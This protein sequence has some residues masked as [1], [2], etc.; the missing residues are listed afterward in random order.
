MHRPGLRFCR[1][2]I[3]DAQILL[4]LFVLYVYL[5]SIVGSMCSLPSVIFL[6]S[7]FKKY[8][9]NNVIKYFI[10]PPCH[11]SPPLFQESHSLIIS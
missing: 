9:M 4:T 10:I 6:S 3:K 11:F 7:Y 5:G 1:K 8:I 2:V